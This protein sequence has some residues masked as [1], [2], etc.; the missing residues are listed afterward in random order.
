MNCGG[1]QHRHEPAEL[2]DDVFPRWVPWVAAIAGAIG[3]ALTWL[4]AAYR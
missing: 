3:L 4:G 1:P 2:H